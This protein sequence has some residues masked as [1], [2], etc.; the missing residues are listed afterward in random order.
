MLEGVIDYA[1]LFPPAKLPLSE[2][3]NEFLGI[4]HGPNKW[5]VDRFAC[6]VG[7]LPELAIELAE[8]P[9][10][11]FVPVA[12]IGTVQ[13]DHKHWKHGLEHD[14]AVMTKFVQAAENHAEIQAYEV[15][16][17]DHAHVTEYVNEL[18]P[19]ANIDLF[20]ELPWSPEMPSSLAMLAEAEVASAKARTGGIEALAFPSPADL[21]E[22]IQQC[23]QLDLGFKLTAGL[24]HPLPTRDEKLGVTMHGFLNVLAATAFASSE[25]LSTRELEEVLKE[26][27]PSAFGFKRDA[28]TWREHRATLDDVEFARTLFFSFG[29]CSVQEPVDGLAAIGL[30]DK[31]SK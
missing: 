19:F 16:L 26:T 20:A 29:S 27:G 24:H 30:Q 18:R 11:P 9:D 2:A 4:V 15:R 31:V 3:V 28:L 6:P 1:G 7:K 23:V 17:P 5:L 8:H 22:F 13:A 14:A 12:V 21:A 25:D 10:E